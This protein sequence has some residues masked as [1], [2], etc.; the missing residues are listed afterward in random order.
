MI[1]PNILWNV[2]HGF[3]TVTHT[4][5]IKR[6]PLATYRAQARGGKGRAGTSLKAS[7][8]SNG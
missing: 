7:T 4:G 8:S 1:L 3:V 6:V 2:S 5:Y